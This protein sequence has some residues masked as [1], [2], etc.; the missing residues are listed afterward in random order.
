MFIKY[1]YVR[2]A[3]AVILI[4]AVGGVAI[5]FLTPSQNAPSADEPAQQRSATKSGGSSNAKPQGLVGQKAATSPNKAAATSK[6]AKAIAAANASAAPN[7]KNKDAFRGKGWKIN[8]YEETGDN[9]YDRA[10]VDKDRDGT[11]DEKWNWKKGRWEK[12]GGA[13]IWSKGAWVSAK[14]ADKAAAEQPADKQPT[15]AAATGDTD[16]ADMAKKILNDRATGAKAKDVS[17]G[18]GPK[19]NFYDDNGDGK[20]DRAKV[21]KDRDDNWDEKWTVKDGTLERKI[22]SSG[23]LKIFKD[24][25]WHTKAK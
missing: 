9:H 6:D 5:Y 8:L 21:D 25:A 13:T 19:F 4:F 23:E 20:W 22:V 3:L 10:K 24:G 7:S 18:R 15:E 11:W 1:Q 12:D 16:M 2:A 14:E 17:R